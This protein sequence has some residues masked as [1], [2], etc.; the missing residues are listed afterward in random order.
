MSQFTTIT[1]VEY[2]S[3]EGM[4]VS[5]R[6]E[7]RARKAC[8]G[9]MG[10]KWVEDML[11]KHFEPGNTSLYNIAPRDEQY[12]QKKRDQATRA[13]QY[14]EAVSRGEK[15]KRRVRPMPFG[16]EVPLVFYG[17]L[18]R[19]VQQH[20]QIHAYPTRCTI[21]M[22]DGS[23]PYLVDNPVSKHTKNIADEI[24]QVTP[25]ETYALTSVGARV[26]FQAIAEAHGRYIYKSEPSG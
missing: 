18:S 20:V 22:G 7:T 25:E 6:A 21:V 9:A 15:P 17:D 4:I 3:T 8:F 23:L 5:K 24:R 12:L 14:Q 16:G 1:Q 2:P 11:P 26:Y 10:E 13:D 19:N